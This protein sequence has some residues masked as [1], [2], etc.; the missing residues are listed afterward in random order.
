MSKKLL[1][2]LIILIG[3]SLACS[4]LAPAR[5]QQTVDIPEAQ[6]TI[7]ALQA[8]LQSQTGSG[9]S[10]DVA[11]IQSTAMAMMSD[12]MEA[13]NSE[14]LEVFTTEGIETI[15]TFSPY[16][17]FAGLPQPGYT[18]MDGYHMV[19]ERVDSGNI[20]WILLGWMS[21]ESTLEN[22]QIAYMDVLVINR[23]D[24]EAWIENSFGLKDVQGADVYTSGATSLL[25]GE[26]QRMWLS[27]IMEPGKQ[28]DILYLQADSSGI[29]AQRILW[30]LGDIPCAV[31]A[32]GKL[33]GERE[34]AS[35]AIGETGRVGNLNITVL[36]IS[37]PE[38]DRNS[39]PGY[40]YVAV[41]LL[42]EN[43][44]SSDV[45]IDATYAGWLKDAANYY[46]GEYFSMDASTI[47]PGGQLQTQAKFEIPEEADGLLFLFDG[48][49]LDFGKAFFKLD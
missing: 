15:E 10:D 8:T 30:D 27:F 37:F 22:T 17:S 44:G 38:K 2:V 48:S 43:T 28:A 24:S 34:M 11:G 5:V 6:Q 45:N 26:R 25:P 13:A 19:G 35:Y 23:G 41:D 7:E 49:Y 20:T 47:F 12:L 18:P 36:G 39:Y 14:E 31:A 1:F 9:D 21:I 32:P 40:K 33:D 46:Y 3:V 29:P 4:I 16:R 42:I